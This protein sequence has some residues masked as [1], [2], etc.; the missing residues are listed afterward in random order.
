MNSL[1]LSVAGAPSPVRV[2]EAVLGGVLQPG[3]SLVKDA[4]D[5]LLL[6]EFRELARPERRALVARLQLG[7]DVGRSAESRGRRTSGGSSG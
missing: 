2:D 4:R 7:L 1:K 6:H 5:A 3:Y